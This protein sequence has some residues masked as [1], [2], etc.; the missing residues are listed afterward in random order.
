MTFSTL[1][2]RIAALCLTAVVATPA[3]AAAEEPTSQDAGVNFLVLRENATGSASAAQGYID[4][5]VAAIARTVG[6]GKASG[7]YV[8]R[9]STAEKFVA[10]SKPQFG[11]IS[12]SAY[13]AL[14]AK[15]DLSV[16]GKADIQSG[17]GHQFFVVSKDEL[18]LAGCKSKTLG[19]NHSDATFIDKVVSGDDFDLADF[20]VEDTRR[21]VKTLK[22]VISGDVACALIDDAQ[23][24]E[25]QHLDGG[26][27]I[28][29][30]WSSASLPPMVVVAFPSADAKARKGLTTALGSVCSGEG[31]SACEAT[32]IK[33]E[34]AGKSALAE[35]EKAYGG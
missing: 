30:V 29:P 12:L 19:T 10:D 34:T 6:W 28:H 4:D 27:D 32:S 25:L 23:L 8:T 33:L 26:L 22:S 5:L 35:Y 2:R 13:L 11:I 21:P 17:G 3:V 31:K 9:R 1:P 15:Y 24:M 18:S 7:K 16:L 14:K 20:E